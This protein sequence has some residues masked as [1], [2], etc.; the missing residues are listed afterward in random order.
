MLRCP[1]CN[2][3]AFRHGLIGY[4]HI[5]RDRFLAL[6]RERAGCAV[7]GCTCKSPSVVA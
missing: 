5:L 6:A 1:D 4:G 2:H 3:L 7:E